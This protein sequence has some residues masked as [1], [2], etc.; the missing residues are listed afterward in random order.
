MALSTNPKPTIYRNLY[1][2]YYVRSLLLLFMIQEA[3]YFSPSTPKDPTFH[4][5]DFKPT[6]IKDQIRCL[7]GAL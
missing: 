5:T 2:T 4:D 6:R 7:E 1:E 3:T